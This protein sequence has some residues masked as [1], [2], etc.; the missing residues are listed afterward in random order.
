MTAARRTLRPGTKFCAARS[1]GKP[2]A[3]L[4]VI[5]GRFAAYVLYTLWSIQAVIPPRGIHSNYHYEVSLL[6]SMSFSCMRPPG[7]SGLVLSVQKPL[8]T[9][10]STCYPI[11]SVP[12]RV[13]HNKL[14]PS[15][16]LY[17]AKHVPAQPRHQ[18]PST[19]G[20]ALLP[21]AVHHCAQ[22]VYNGIRSP[23]LRIFSGGSMFHVQLVP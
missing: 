16:A 19:Y 7:T 1:E 22:H 13:R 5:D 6:Q 17:P 10:T 21:V 3:P 15:A 18:V 20:A 14:Q 23:L 8:R 4:I 2:R 12:V 9:C 11:E